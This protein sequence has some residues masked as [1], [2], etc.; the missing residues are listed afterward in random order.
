MLNGEYVAVACGRI[1]VRK[2]SQI[3][4]S[5]FPDVV[6]FGWMHAHA[7]VEIPCAKR[8]MRCIRIARCDEAIQE[9]AS[10]I[11]GDLLRAR[12]ERAGL[13]EVVVLKADHKDR[14]YVGSQKS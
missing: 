10:R 7:G 14:A 2:N 11:I 13:G 3:R 1:F 5:L 12:A 6:W 4:P 9:G 8:Y